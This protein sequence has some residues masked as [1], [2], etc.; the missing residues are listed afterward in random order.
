MAA[1]SNPQVVSFAR[2][3]KHGR[4]LNDTG[5]QRAADSPMYALHDSLLLSLIAPQPL[6]AARLAL[7]D[8]LGC[9]GQLDQQEPATTCSHGPK[10]HHRR[11]PSSLD[12]K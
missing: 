10:V 3:D 12:V 5:K 4:R 9:S 6:L 7:L 8:G 1:A 2:V 11:S